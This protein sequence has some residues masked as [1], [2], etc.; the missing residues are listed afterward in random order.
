MGTDVGTERSKQSDLVD[1]YP[2]LLENQ[3]YATMNANIMYEGD[4]DFFGGLS[5]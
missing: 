5:K 1:M 3:Y 2:S 4:N